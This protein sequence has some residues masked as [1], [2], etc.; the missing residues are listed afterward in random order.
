MSLI[1][2]LALLGCGLLAA[3]TVIMVYFIM[4]DREK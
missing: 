4:R 2:L 1:S 3:V